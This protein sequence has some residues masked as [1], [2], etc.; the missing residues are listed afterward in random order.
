MS[1]LSTTV[2]RGL[3]VTA[4]AMAA[5]PVVGG[6]ASAAT[7]PT[8]ST[9]LDAAP[10]TTTAAD[11]AQLATAPMPVTRS[12]LPLAGG[13]GSIM[14]INGDLAGPVSGLAGGLP[15][16][17]LTG[18]LPVSG[19]TGQL[20]VVGPMAQ[21]LPVVG[22]LTGA[23][24]AT[25]PANAQAAQ[26]AAADLKAAF[27]TP[28]MPTPPALMTPAHAGTRSRTLAPVAP[29]V[30]APAGPTAAQVAQAQQAAAAANQSGSSLPIIGQLPVVGGLTQGLPV[31]NLTG[32]LGHF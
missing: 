6:V 3:V 15:L 2:R 7:G 32:A 13:L 29:A 23:T 19:L 22:Q 9:P 30:A 26:D 20:P 11:T 17:Q 5:G 8:T 16:N 28:H 10:I 27:P 14:P 1:T 24:P 31:G 21:N 12:A 25:P 18:G 4:A